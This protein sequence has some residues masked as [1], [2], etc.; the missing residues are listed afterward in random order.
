MT[1]TGELLNFIT[2]FAEDRRRLDHLSKL[3]ALGWHYLCHD[4][5]FFNN[6]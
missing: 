2:I 5:S 3:M 4:K 6:I 1:N